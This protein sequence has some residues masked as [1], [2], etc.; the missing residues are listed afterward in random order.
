M[1][2]THRPLPGCSLL[3]VIVALTGCSA[4]TSGM[5]ECEVTT[6]ECSVQQCPDSPLQNTDLGLAAANEMMAWMNPA[7]LLRIPC[8]PPAPPCTLHP[9]SASGRCDVAAAERCLDHFDRYLRLVGTAQEV[10][11][12]SIF[13]G[14][15]QWR[16]LH[17]CSDIE[18]WVAAH[19][20]LRVAQA[21]AAATLCLDDHEFDQSLTEVDVAIRGLRANQPSESRPGRLACTPPVTAR[22]AGRCVV[23]RTRLAVPVAADVSTTTH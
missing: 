19:N 21:R 8:L 10:V 6:L 16:W 12:A 2:R 4:S 7:L 17:A 9:E 22:T 13:Q 3:V 20:A 5:G 11:A 18:G 15:R 23:E 1:L 14:S